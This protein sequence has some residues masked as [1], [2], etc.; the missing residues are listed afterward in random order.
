MQLFGVSIF[1][2]DENANP[3]LDAVGVPKLNPANGEGLEGSVVV[4]VVGVEVLEAVM[5]PRENPEAVVEGEPLFPKLNLNPP[6][7]PNDT[8]GLLDSSLD[9]TSSSWPGL[10]V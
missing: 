10:A 1:C 7:A 6:P 9:L 4:D 3:V 2:A 8:A 5:P